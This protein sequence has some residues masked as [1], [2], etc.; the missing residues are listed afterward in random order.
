MVAQESSWNSGDL[1]LI[2]GL[3]LSPGE[4]NGYPLQY[5]GLE[6][7]MDCMVRGVTKSWTQL[8]DC[9]FHY[10]ILK[11]LCLNICFN[12]LKNFYEWISSIHL[13]HKYLLAL[14]WRQIVCYC[15][16]LHWAC[17]EKMMETQSACLACILGHFL[18][19]RLF[20]RLTSESTSIQRKS[21]ELASNNF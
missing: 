18:F 8:S 10:R 1:G 9:H 20:W 15:Y 6:N 3:G 17:D 16:I 5:S 19:V 7:S 14:Y 21:L 2:P 12:T 4:E 13:L 11:S